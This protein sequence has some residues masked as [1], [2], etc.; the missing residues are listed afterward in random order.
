M[1]KQSS[2]FQSIS[3]WW[4]LTSNLSMSEWLDGSVSRPCDEVPDPNTSAP[5]LDRPSATDHQ[6]QASFEPKSLPL[7]A[8]G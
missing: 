8:T 1:N 6:G 3:D 4:N 5:G 7:A 2:E